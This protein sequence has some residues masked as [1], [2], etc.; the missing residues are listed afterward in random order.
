MPHYVR[1]GNVPHKRHT[2]FRRPDG[3]LYSEEV[4]GAEGFSGISSIAYHV[5]PPTVVDKVL[6]PIPFGVEYTEL[7]FLR[8]RHVRGFNV[9]SEG[10]WLES[11]RYVMGN[12]D[13]RLAVATPT[14]EMDYFYR[15]AVADEMIYVHDGEGVLES[16]F[17]NVPFRKG[18]YVHVPRTITHRWRFN[19]GPRRLL[20][21]ESF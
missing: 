12:D 19:E 7:D 17:G 9:P 11:R 2:Q 20:V 18:D 8:H 10:A 3:Q 15:N 16:P 21:I 14:Q 13:V 4:I 5:H 1:M 6:D